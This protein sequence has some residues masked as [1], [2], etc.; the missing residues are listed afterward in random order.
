L[1]KGR[2]FFPLRQ[3]CYAAIP[4][5]LVRLAWAKTVVKTCER[6]IGESVVFDIIE[7]PECG[8]EGYCLANR[9]WAEWC[10]TVARL[11]TPWEIIHSLDKL[12]EPFFDVRL[13]A[14][15]ERTSARRAYAIS[16]PSQ[17]IAGRLRKPWGLKP[18]EVYPNPLPTG[19][20]S[21]TKGKDWVYTGRV[22]RRKGVHLLVKAYAQ[23]CSNR[24]PPPLRLVGRSYG[25]LPCGR[26]YGDYIREL[27]RESGMRERITWIEG[28]P[29][30]S[31]QEFLGRSSVA[32]FP[33][34][35]EN[36]SYACLEA[37]ASGCAVVASDC[38][39]YPEMITRNKSGLLFEPGNVASL[40]EAMYRLIDREA[41][42]RELGQEA[43]KQV[44][45]QCDQS[46][47]CARAEEFYQSL[48]ERYSH[49]RRPGIAAH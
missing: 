33:S 28:V 48:L 34:L 7:Y 13:Q 16:A 38:G 1:P 40:A 35:W 18:V 36:F 49:G 24:S 15:M 19:S 5:S 27:I 20:Y 46:T 21:L 47:V 25:R 30:G 17:A 31:V 26:P 37:M 8:G 42:A 32:F 11:H 22:E 12:K 41:L 44:R 14:M 6:I 9:K 3:L 45:L 23:T 4:Q 43:R 29:N 10:V 39:G 2:L